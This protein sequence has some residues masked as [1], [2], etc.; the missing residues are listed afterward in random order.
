MNKRRS[1][2]E[3]NVLDNFLFN[4]LLND[5]DCNQEFC[6]IILS[7]ILNRDF[8]NI[9]VSPQKQLIGTLSL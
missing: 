7:T 2:S 9:K 6:R 4:E 3:L 8:K 5:N 1:L